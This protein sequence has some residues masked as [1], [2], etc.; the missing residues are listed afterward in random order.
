MVEEA[1]R[2][3]VHLNVGLRES[4]ALQQHANALRRVPEVVVR[5]LV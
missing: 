3:P 4:R 1:E 2:A 5:Q